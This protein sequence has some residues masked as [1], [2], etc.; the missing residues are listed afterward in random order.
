MIDYWI[1]WGLG[2]IFIPRM[3]IGIMLIVLG[4][5]FIGIILALIGLLSDVHD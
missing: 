4:H 2:W 5:P 3:T 1:L